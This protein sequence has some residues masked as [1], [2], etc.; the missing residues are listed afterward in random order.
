VIALHS[1]RLGPAAG[2]CRLWQYASNGDAITDALRLSEGMTYKNALA[3]IPFGGGKSVMLSDGSPVNTRQLHV[4]GGSM[5]DRQGRYITAEDVGMG[6]AQVREIAT[7]SAHV[8]GLGES[9]V[10]GGPSPM[11]A[12]GV[13][14]GLK[15]VVD[16]HYGSSNLH[17]L[18]I[19]VQGLGN[20][21]IRFVCAG[22]NKRAALLHV[23]DINPQRVAEATTFYGAAPY[24]PEELLDQ[25][26]DVFVPCALGGVGDDQVAAH[27]DIQVI[28]GAANNQLA[29]PAAGQI[30]ADR[31]ILFAPD[32]VLNAGGVI[33][34]AHEIMSVLGRLGVVH[35]PKEW[36]ASRVAAIAERLRSILSEP[37]A[38]AL[39]PQEVA[40]ARAK[41][42]L[43]D[44]V[45]GQQ[46]FLVTAAS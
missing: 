34:V 28:A 21:G 13:F 15:T 46:G 10:G 23:D 39:P 24:S 9:G 6:I 17:G 33:S 43:D 29:N 18:K 20:V 32:F 8:S 37:N 25:T 4:F 41:Q 19:G 22:T 36:V 27:I 44:H 14:V 42:I 40:I 31:K 2:G 26:M 3:S 38:Q 11:P 45:D 1:T 5:N 30:L 7:K 16:L 35:D 12:Y